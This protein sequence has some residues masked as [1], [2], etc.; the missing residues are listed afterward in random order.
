[1]RAYEC[2]HSGLLYPESYVKEWG[3]NGHGV[4]LGPTPVS[5]CLDT[6]YNSG[7]AIPDHD[8]SEAMHPVGV[9]RAALIPVNVTEEEFQKRAAILHRDDPRMHKRCEI[10]RERQMKKSSHLKRHMAQ[11]KDGEK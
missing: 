4:G 5:E 8:A 7:L 10:I 2:A 9:T 11:V 6:D 3:R 1:M